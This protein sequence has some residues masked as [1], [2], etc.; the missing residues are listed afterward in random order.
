M[1]YYKNSWDLSDIRFKDINSAYQRIEE[2]ITEIEGYKTSFKKIS[3]KKFHNIL[4]LNEELSIVSDR[5][6][7]PIYLK[8]SENCNNSKANQEMAKFKNIMT[9]VSNRLIFLNHYITKMPSKKFNYLKGGLNEDQIIVL[10]GVRAEKKYMLSQKVEEIASLKDSTGISVVLS[11]YNKLTSSFKFSFKK[12]KKI[13]KLTESEIAFYCNNPDRKLREKAYKKINEKYE[14]FGSII[15]D[16]YMAKVKNWGDNAKLRGYKTPI[17]V[18]NRGN[19]ISDKIIEN[20]LESTRE[21]RFLFQNYFKLKKKVCDIKGKFKRTDIYAPSKTKINKKI[22]FKEAV[23]IVLETFEQFSPEYKKMAELMFKERHVH[24][25]KSKNKRSGAYCMGVPPGFLPYVFL[26]YNGSLNDV[27]TLAH[28]LGHALHDILACKEHNIF[29]NHPSLPLAETA[30]IFSERLLSDRLM[31]E[32]KNK[33]V[34]KQLLVERIDGSFASV[35]RQSYFVIFEKQAHDLINST[36]GT[37]LDELCDLYMSTLEEQFGNTIE[38]Q[39]HFKNE[40]MRIPHIF[41]T[42]F[43]CY[44]YSIGELLT[45]SLFEEYKEK[46]KEFV[47]KHKRIL[48]AGGSDIPEYILKNED[49][50]ISKKDFWQKGFDIIKKDVIDLEKLL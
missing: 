47:S 6:Y 9:N 34:K 15:S 43:Y 3:R 35:L 8:L 31:S 33:K 4:N 28:E 24:S 45:L 44:A 21:N 5:I 46:G 16:C 23:K 41:R 13:K 36:E 49:I 2:I 29:T 20:M 18:R 37:N 48:S 42:P 22:P 39:K 40:W 7:T 25:I 1:E 19:E 12:G 50:D 17:S 27:S 14:E 26:N 38:I 10:D 32:S 30:S 11:N